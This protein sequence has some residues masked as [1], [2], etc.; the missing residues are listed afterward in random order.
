ML[1]RDSVKL[2]AALDPRG[3][4]ITVAD[5][6]VA[7]GLSLENAERALHRL[8]AEYRGHLSATEKGELLFRFPNGFSKPWET[9]GALSRA[10][11]A[12][13]RGFMGV[14]RFI[15]RAWVAIVLVAYVAIFVALLIGFAF[16]RSSDDRRSSG[17][18]LSIASGLFRLLAEAFF[19]TAHPFSPFY[20]PEIYSS[21]PWGARRH[22][23]EEPK[24]P[25]YERVDR[26][27][28]GPKEP[29][30]DPDAPT[31]AILAEIRA[32]KGRIGLADV[33]RI[34]GQPRSEVD[35]LMSRLMIQYH[36]SVEVSDDGGI[37]YQFPDL[38][39]TAASGGA[40]RAPAIWDRPESMPPVTGNTPGTN[41]LIGGL[42][43][44]NLM[45]SGWMLAS[46]LTIERLVAMF[47][48]IPPK[49]WPAPGTPIV[50]G[51]IPFVFS[52]ALFALPLVRL[53]FRPLRERKVARENGRRAMLKAILESRESGGVT[54]AKLK[55]V[56]RVASGKDPTD[57]E[58]TNQVVSLGGDVDVEDSQNGV[59]YRFRDLELERR[60]VEAERERASEEEA[61]VGKVVFSSEN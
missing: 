52:I 60:A 20:S 37:Y 9:R 51:V 36:G 11:T 32:A 16:A 19:W 21:D 14:L 22:Q 59:R 29:P 46:G 28:F 27:F 42:N 4:H 31:R 26:F 13:G 43:A 53:A 38:R 61:Q 57:K 7:S 41:L 55:D 40:K 56:Y 1:D 8:V 10:A 15:V 34:T 5:A 58:I 3:Q 33:I 39:K 18:S 47:S 25:F 54:D 6:S 44:F 48:K 17:P 24:S 45:M 12:V 30:P 50:L 23:S 35:P 49:N 2:R